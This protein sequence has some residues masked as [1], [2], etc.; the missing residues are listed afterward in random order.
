MFCRRGVL[1]RHLFQLAALGI[2]SAVLAACNLPLNPPTPAAALTPAAID[3]SLAPL[4][5]PTPAPTLVPPT[6]T[7][8]LCPRLLTPENGARL[9]A[10]G[11]VTFSWEPVPDAAIY[12]LEIT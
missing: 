2:G 5:S 11:R 7:P 8:D 3:N 10:T 12:W 6:P 4:P 9:P 1:P